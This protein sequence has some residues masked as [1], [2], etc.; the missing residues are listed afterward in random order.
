M[1]S[2]PKFKCATKNCNLQKTWFSLLTSWFD[3]SLAAPLP[4]NTTFTTHKHTHVK[5]KSKRNPYRIGPRCKLVS[6]HNATLAK[7]LSVGCKG[8]YNFWAVVQRSP[9]KHLGVW[10]GKFCAGTLIQPT[11]KERSGH[12]YSSSVV[13]LL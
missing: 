8:C 6:Q 3:L 12:L 1:H 13:H 11:L 7:G 10:Q 9:E 4:Q 5:E 2:C